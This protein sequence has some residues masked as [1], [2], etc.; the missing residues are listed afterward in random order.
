MRL[1]DLMN[2]R[3]HTVCPT[4][5]VAHARALMRQHD[6]HHLPVLD[7]DELVGMLGER[8]LH[9]PALEGLPAEAARRFE[10]RPVRDVM[11]EPVASLGPRATAHDAA[12][13]LRGRHFGAVPVVDRGR[14]VGIVTESDLL[15]LV[16][17]S[18]A[19]V[20]PRSRSRDSGSPA[21]TVARSRRR[22]QPR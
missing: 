17:R 4:D 19:A 12:N 11:S 6:L 7:G 16:S 14:V 5:T 22:P 10:E 15:E 3:V 8:D 21:V 9:A 13:L 2:K 1:C 20:A 18:S